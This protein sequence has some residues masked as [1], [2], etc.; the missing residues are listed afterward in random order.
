MV[1]I[2]VT[3]GPKE[4]WEGKALFRLAT[5]R[6]GSEVE[7]MGRGASYWLSFHGLLSLLAYITQDYL[8]MV[9]CHTMAW[10]LPDQSLKKCL[11]DSPIGH[12]LF[13]FLGIS[14]ISSPSS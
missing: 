14:P 2:A 4:T 11:T 13:H 3:P 10:A 12:F 6:A 5:L 8:P 1:T 9:A 7:A